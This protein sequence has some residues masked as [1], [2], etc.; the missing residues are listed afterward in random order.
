M[1]RSQSFMRHDAGYNA[2][3]SVPAGA[4]QW[5]DTDEGRDSPGQSFKVSRRFLR[6]NKSCF[7]GEDGQ[8]QVQVKMQLTLQVW[9][10]ILCL[11]AISPPLALA[12]FRAPLFAM[13]PSLFARPLSFAMPPLF[14][15]AP[16]H[17]L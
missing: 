2:P 15:D 17:R 1:H 16:L 4:V 14:F 11:F 7:V 10:Y 6:D 9:R 12:F 5:A 3:L 8:L 13:P